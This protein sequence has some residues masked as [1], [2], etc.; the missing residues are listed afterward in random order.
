MCYRAAASHVNAARR[1]SSAGKERGGPEGPPRESRLTGSPEAPGAP[2]GYGCTIATS[3]DL[4][5]PWQF[6]HCSDAMFAWA[7]LRG[8]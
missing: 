2:S 5:E 8:S 1:R 4:P 3:S 6:R 7:V